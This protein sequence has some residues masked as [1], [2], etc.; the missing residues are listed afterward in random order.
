LG[1]D[2]FDADTDPDPTFLAFLALFSKRPCSFAFTWI[3]AGPMLPSMLLIAAALA[4]ELDTAL[5]LCS[6]R[7]KVPG[8]GVPLWTGTR[9]KN[10]LHFLKLGVGP[11]RS[12][13]VLQR[14]LNSLKPKSI[15]VLGY[16]GALDP[17]LTQ[18]ELVVLEHAGLLPEEFWDDPAG[19]ISP[20]PRWPLAPS[21]ELCAAAK[22]AGLPVRRGTSLTSSH[23]VG[24]PEVKQILFGRFHA[25]VVDME[26]AALAPVAA[27]AAVPLRCVRAVGDEAS[28]DFLAFLSYNPASGPWQRAVQGLAAGRWLRRY[29]QWRDRSE[30]ARRSLH[31]FMVWYLDNV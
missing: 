20:G 9:G 5:N 22:A 10:L 26:T 8:A 16:A 24:A 3:P 31:R 15:L 28:D 11:A 6:R 21:E 12:A 13:D 27:A 17:A 4:E 14:A 7:R 30:A 2:I 1:I 23:I 29:S 25:A 18:G 19:E